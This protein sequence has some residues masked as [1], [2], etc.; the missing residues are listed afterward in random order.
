MSRKFLTP[1]DLTQL[2]LLNARIQNLT[3]TQINAI[4]T[5]VFGQLVYDTTV[6][7]LKV[8]VPNAWTPVGSVTTGTGAPSTT[9]LS[10]GSTYFDLTTNTLYV[11]NGTTSS[12]NWVVA[13]ARGETADIA[14]L[15]SANAAGTSIRVANADHVH[16]HTDTDHSDI[17]LNALATATGDYSMGGYKLTNLAD[18]T[19]AQDAATKNYVDSV[20]QGLNVKDEVQ[21]AS[22]T[23]IDGTYT[24]GSTGADGGAGVG[25][26]FAVTATGALVIDG[27]TLVLNDRVLL[28]NQTTGTQNGIYRVSTAGTVSVAPVLTRTTD[29]DNHIPAQ[30][31][32]GDFVFVINGT[33][34]GGTGWAQTVQGT[35]TNPVKTI[36]LG[37]DAL[38]YAQFSGTGTYTASN[39]VLLTGTNFT[40]APSTTGGLTTGSSGGAILLDTN[41]AIETTSTGTKVKPGLGITTSGEGTAGDATADTVAI[42][43]DVVARKVTATIGNNSATSFTVT[44]NLSTQFVSVT[45]FDADTFAEVFA[46]VVHTNDDTV[47]ITFAVAPTTDAY[48]VIVIG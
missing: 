9:P 32:S 45:V 38:A 41:A 4:A 29:Y 11:S 19:N 44:H 24:P 1:I 26:T 33:T 16:R 10:S 36:K 28:K 37:T 21:A 48:K 6:A 5:P 3:T 8:Y 20:A 14:N 40:F 12:A 27:V 25:A 39:G 30:V 35:S 15:G 42:D 46:D 34:Q 43:T 47:T 17:H 31:T 2:E 22:T 7:T 13:Q 18:P 23:N